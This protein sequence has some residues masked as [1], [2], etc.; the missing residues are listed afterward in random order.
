M[1]TITDLRADVDGGR[2]ILKGLDLQIPTGEVHAVMGPNGSGKSTLSHVIAGREGY[3]VSG[4]VT[5]DG[6]DILGLSLEERTS[7]G[8]FVAL[9]YPHEIPGVGNY[10][11]LRTAL[12]AQR[13]ARGEP[14][15]SASELLKILRE[16]LTT[17]QMDTSF[18]SRAVNEGF[19]GGE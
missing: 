11:F 4:S 15:A 17:L 19:S 14:L 16:P 18:L 12:N 6:E 3:D 13:E 10:N 2:S 1:I 8:I 5:L 7:Q 9:Q